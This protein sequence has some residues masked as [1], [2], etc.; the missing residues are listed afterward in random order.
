MSTV[1]RQALIV[2]N[3]EAVL[4]R[5]QRRAAEVHD[6]LPA[7]GIDHES[8]VSEDRGHAIE[9]ARRAS[10]AGSEL[11]VAAGGDGTINEVVNGLM[12]ARV[13]GA[14]ALGIPLDLRQAAQR[15]A[16]GQARRIDL[17]RVNG[18]FFDNNVWLGFEAMINA[19][20]PARLEV[21]A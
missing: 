11:I 16:S 3:P 13:E 19:G 9:L 2:F 12:L 10:L 21:I 15:L 20:E 5:G 18:R 14:Y 7:A 1:N 8:V 17:G 4:G 6:A